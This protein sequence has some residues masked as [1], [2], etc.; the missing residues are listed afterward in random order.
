MFRIVLC[1]CVNLF[2]LNSFYKG[3]FCKLCGQEAVLH[4]LGFN[5]AF[6]LCY[7]QVIIF[8]LTWILEDTTYNYDKQLIFEQHYF[9]KGDWKEIL[10]AL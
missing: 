8:N 6:I 7:P 9:P 1:S 10:F 3:F 4:S 5:L 2:F